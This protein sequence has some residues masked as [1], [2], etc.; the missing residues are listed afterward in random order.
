MQKVTKPKALL[1]PY[2]YH[3]I[4]PPPPPTHI[5]QECVSGYAAY[6]SRQ[7]TLLQNQTYNVY[8]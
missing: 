4:H 5:L 7:N 3:S 1:S 8:S 6:S 2:A